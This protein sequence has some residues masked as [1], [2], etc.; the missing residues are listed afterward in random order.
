MKLSLMHF[1][2]H[3]N[4]L[5]VPSEKDFSLVSFFVF[6]LTSIFFRSSH[7][8]KKSHSRGVASIVQPRGNGDYLLWTSRLQHTNPQKESYVISF[9]FD[10]F[11]AI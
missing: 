6:Q 7:Q 8:K 2:N 5:S 3:V 1:E 9:S 11:L 10:L 4:D